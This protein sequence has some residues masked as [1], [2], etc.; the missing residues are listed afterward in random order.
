M[1][2]DDLP[3]FSQKLPPD[4]EALIN[5]FDERP[6]SNGYG[7]GKQKKHRKAAFDRLADIEPQPV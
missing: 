2:D 6:K 1:M 7:H 5:G 3:P 4:L